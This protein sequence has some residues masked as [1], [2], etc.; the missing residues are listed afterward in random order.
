MAAESEGI[1]EAES[2]LG[3][4]SLVGGVVQ[5]ALGIR[6]VQVDGRRN[7]TVLDSQD[8]GNGL[9]RTGSSEHMTVHRLCGGDVALVCVISHSQFVCLGLGNVVETGSG[10]VGID[11]YAVL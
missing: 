6:V 5:V 2:D 3:F 11:V 9:Y 8:G 1:A 7:D 10:A 4:L